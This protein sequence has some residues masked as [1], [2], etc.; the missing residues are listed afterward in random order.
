MYKNLLYNKIDDFC[1]GHLLQDESDG[2]LLVGMVLLTT[3]VT[4]FL[5]PE[6]SSMRVTAIRKWVREW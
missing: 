2:S 6:E 5:K 3:V 4:Q 1:D